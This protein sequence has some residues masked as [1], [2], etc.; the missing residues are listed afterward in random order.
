MPLAT[1]KSAAE[2]QLGA[3]ILADGK[4]L[5]SNHQFYLA[6]RPYAEKNPEIVR[7]VI[8]K[9]A[10]VDDWGRQ[11]QKEAAAILSAQIGLDPAIVELA[12]T[13]YT[14]GVKP[15]S[16][17]VISEQ[18]KIADVFTN[19]KLIPKKINVRDAVLSSKL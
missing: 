2:R 10:K 18:Q 12:A 14:Y 7:L 13:R 17:A 9:L 6:S 8:E 1:P 19:L 3:R 15:I 16:D 11:N 4:G 5:V